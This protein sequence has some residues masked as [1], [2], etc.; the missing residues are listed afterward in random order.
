VW[1]WGE[2]IQANAPAAQPAQ[3]A[4]RRRRW[5][6]GSCPCREL[7]AGGWRDHLVRLRS[8][9][10]L[11]ITNSEKAGCGP[12][13]GGGGASLVP[14]RLLQM[15]MSNAKFVAAALAPC[16]QGLPMKSCMHAWA[17]ASMFCGIWSPVQRAGGPAQLPDGSQVPAPTPAAATAAARRQLRL[18]VCLQHAARTCLLHPARTCLLHLPPTPSHGIC[19]TEPQ[20]TAIA[21]ARGGI[22]CK[23]CSGNHMPARK[24]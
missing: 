10:E 13:V 6:L 23:L 3:A 8:S 9:G 11:R 17:A 18:G 12:L 4:Q 20:H 1:Q 19:I 7:S 14:G 2:Q 24:R 15:F 16:C 22:A 5:R 21:T